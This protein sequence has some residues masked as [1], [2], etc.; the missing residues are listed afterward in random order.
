MKINVAGI[1]EESFSDGPGIRYVV[2]AQGCRHQCLGCH[3]PETHSFDG[4]QWIDIRNVLRGM[5]KNPLLD[6]ITLSGGDPFEQADAF[7]AL[8]KLAK[9]NGYHVMAY[10]GYLFEFLLEHRE[11][12]G[13]GR[14][15]TWIDVLVDG[16]FDLARRFPPSRFRGSNNQKI[17]DVQRSLAS[18]S[19]IMSTI[20]ESVE[21]R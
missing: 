4:G 7:G 1:I 9:K 20:N 18:Q 21:H 12:R 10:T 19:V 2:F 16:P 6:G 5:K 14:L 13:W 15:L 3:N 17:V 8:A 11:E